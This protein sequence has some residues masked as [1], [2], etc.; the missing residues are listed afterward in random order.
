[1]TETVEPRRASVGQAG[2]IV[3]HA[4]METGAAGLPLPARLILYDRL[5]AEAL[6]HLSDYS[7]RNDHAVLLVLYRHGSPDDEALA[8]E[9]GADECLPVAF[10][11]RHLRARL[12]S[13]AHSLARLGPESG[14]YLQ[15]DLDTYQVVVRGRRV[16]V[17]GRE[18]SLLRELW[19]RRR[20]VVPHAELERTLYGEEGPAVRQAVRQLV[21][22]VRLRLGPAARA[23]QCVPGIGYILWPQLPDGAN[24]LC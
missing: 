5:D 12:L 1:M 13:L 4:V 17:S 8:L 10:N 14:D 3:A 24:N 23:L 11:I 15:L 19:R 18:F 9:A 2:A 21:R 6:A 20:Q 7:A 16:R 22:R